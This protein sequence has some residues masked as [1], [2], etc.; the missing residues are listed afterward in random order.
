MLTEDRHERILEYL[1][2]RGSSSIKELSKLIGASESTIRRDI[3]F[4]E[5]HGLLTKVYGGAASLERRIYTKEPDMLKKHN[6]YSDEK[7]RI[8]QYAASL[9]KK[10]D[11]V[12]IDAGTTTEAVIRYLTEKDAIYITNGLFQAQL[13]TGRGFNT[14]VV[15]G[16]VRSITE[17]IVGEEAIHQIQDCNFSVGFFGTNGITIENGYTTPNLVEASFKRNAL[18]RTLNAYVLADP[19]KFG[20]VYPKTFG[21]ITEAQIITTALPDNAYTTE[22]IIK[23]VDV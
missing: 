5:K 13:L 16:M 15:G 1:K 18:K 6:L 4:L 22:T 19:S 14:Y 11:F 8:G 2:A 3:S 12:F 20:K 10:G 7:E 23:E 17:A 9:V 21:N